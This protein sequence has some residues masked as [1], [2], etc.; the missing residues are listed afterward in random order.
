MDKATAVLSLIAPLPL[1]PAPA[2]P[3]AL[4]GEVA[5]ATGPPFELLGATLPVVWNRRMSVG[6]IGASGV[7]VH[8]WR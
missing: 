5:V 3:E 8:H 4:A 2:L 1:P 6:V 7:N